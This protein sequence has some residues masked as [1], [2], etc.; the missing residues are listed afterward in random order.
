MRK[1]L[2]LLL[3]CFTFAINASEIVV[4][5]DKPGMNLPAAVF[6]G[7][8]ATMTAK[9]SAAKETPANVNAFLILPEKIL[10]DTGV[11]GELLNALSAQKVTPEEITVVLL[12]HAH[13]D[14]ISGLID[15][16]GKANFPNAEIYFAQAELDFWLN[17][18]DEKKLPN[19]ELLKNVLAAYQ[20]NTPESKVKITQLGGEILPKIFAHDASGHTPGH[21]IFETPEL[22]LVGDLIHSAAW[23]VTNPEVYADFDIDPKKASECKREF[24]AKIAASNKKIAGAHLPENGMG[25]ITKSDAGYE[26]VGEK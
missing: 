9:I 3:L 17:V 12:T 14:H 25:K 10:I 22:W 26:F 13:F 11:G 16:N 6:H 24:Y 2:W 4:L 18:A 21:T 15:Q 8:S 19:K 20:Y 23:Q 1:V 7:G 5:K